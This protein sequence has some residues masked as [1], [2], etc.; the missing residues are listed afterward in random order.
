[1]GISV[2]FKKLSDK[3]RIPR[4]ET[5]GAAGL[6]LV[7]VE[8]VTL[9]KGKVCLVPT[10]LAVQ[11]EQGYELQ[12]RARSGLA[13]KHGVF[14]VNGVGTVDSDYRGEIK[15]IMSTCLDTPI[16]LKAGE[17]V[18]QAVIAK[19]EQ[20]RIVELADLTETARGAGGFGSTGR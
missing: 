20:A 15:I 11:V 18:A 16:T 7:S 19:C 4:Y 2:A 12:I 13:A 14:L 1:M 17:R 9:E 10:G 6:D 5:P 8:E 3:A